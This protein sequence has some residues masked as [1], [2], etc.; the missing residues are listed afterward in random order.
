MLMKWSD[1]EVG[2]ILKIRDCVAIQ[3]YNDVFVKEFAYKR[4]KITKV[5]SD[6]VITKLSFVGEN[7]RYGSTVH[8]FSETGETI[9][10][11]EWGQLFEII[12]LRG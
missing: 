2:D 12:E 1:L 5:V 10:N 3:G 6:T 8:I 7:C 9:S 11:P 4:L